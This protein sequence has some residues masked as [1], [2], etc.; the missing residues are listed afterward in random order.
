MHNYLAD[1]L[2]IAGLHFLALVSPGPDFV[3]ITR[4]SLVYSRKTGI[5]SALGLA[6]GIVVHISYCL[7]GIAYIISQSI[8]IFSVLKLLGAGYLIFIGYKSIRAKPSVVSDVIEDKKD[9]GKF[10]A[11]KM[12]FLTNVFNPKATLFFLALFTQVIYP[13]TPMA[14]KLGYGLEMTAMTFVWFSF[15]ALVLSHEKIKKPFIKIQHYVER[16][17]GAALILLGLKVALSKGK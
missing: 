10:A 2:L 3:M 12:G 1:F 6:L 17:A 13:G 11:L 8:I 5:M 4:N 14:I 7:I 9:M 15:V 16:V